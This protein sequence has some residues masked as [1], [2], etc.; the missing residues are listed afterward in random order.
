MYIRFKWA[1]MA[2][3]RTGF[4]SKFF[5][6]IVF[7]SPVFKSFSLSPLFSPSLLVLLFYLE[8]QVWKGEAVEKHSI[9]RACHEG[10]HWLTSA[11]RHT[12]T[13]GFA[14]F[15][16]TE[17]QQSTFPLSLVGRE[18]EYSLPLSCRQRELRGAGPFTPLFAALM[19]QVH[20]V[21]CVNANILKWRSDFTQWGNLLINPCIRFYSYSPP[22]LFLL[23]PLIVT[24]YF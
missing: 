24:N 12:M 16:L 7:L 1:E 4:H 6:H 5:W 20:S 14:I 22:F 2:N 10:I 13:N 11:S 17:G 15:R 8:V 18:R 19:G 21:W 3:R 9:P 23:V